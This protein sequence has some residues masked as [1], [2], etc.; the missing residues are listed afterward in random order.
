MLPRWHI[1][2]GL[3]F[4]LFI[5]FIFPELGIFNA[6][7][8]FF[9]SVFID[10]DHYLNAVV[11]TNSLGLLNAFA[12]YKIKAKLA[13]EE[14]REGIKNKADF[15]FFHTIEFH[16]LVLLLGFIWSGFIY[17]FIG[18]LFHSILDVIYMTYN[19]VLYAREF[20]FFNWLIQRTK[21]S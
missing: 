4:F 18:V 3:I 10:F 2:Y 19:D 13:E 7:L 21:Q 15:Q 20:F 8:I 17:I 14:H 11:K 16:I 5:Y 12:Y 9:A 6:F 1:F